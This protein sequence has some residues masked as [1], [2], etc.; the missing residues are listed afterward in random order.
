MTTDA[1]AATVLSTATH[2]KDRA[3]VRIA[4]GLAAFSVACC[5][6][7]VPLH[8]WMTARVELYPQFWSDSLLGS[9]W[10]VVGALV[11]RSRPRNP[12]G[13]IMMITS[14]IGPYVLLAHY[15]VISALISP[16]P[17]PGADFAAWVGSWGFLA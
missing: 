7:V 14:L 4:A 1:P 10:P 5:V 11:V 8:S 12:V 13:W 9:V 16:T 2:R 17:L 15:A 6:A 3:L